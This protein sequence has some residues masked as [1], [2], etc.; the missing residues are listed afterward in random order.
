MA[1]GLPLTEA[2]IAVDLARR[3]TGTGAGD[4]MAIEQ[5]RAAILSG[6]MRA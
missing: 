5:D 1:A 4:R 3:Q 2:L 6:V